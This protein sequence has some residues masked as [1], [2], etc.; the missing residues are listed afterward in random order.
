MLT[1]PMTPYDSQTPK[2]NPSAI[3]NPKGHLPSPK[4]LGVKRLKSTASYSSIR[5]RYSTS[6]LERLTTEYV[7]NTK[8]Q[9]SI[10]AFSGI[11][12]TAGLLFNRM[13][14]HGS[15]NSQNKIL[16]ARLIACS[17]VVLG[18]LGPVAAQDIRFP[19]HKSI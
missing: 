8:F 6:L 10:L 14:N 11:L 9:D 7:M 2:S 12:R 16:F 18:P 4:L 13:S 3:Q 19:S 5:R 17:G 1:L 15:L